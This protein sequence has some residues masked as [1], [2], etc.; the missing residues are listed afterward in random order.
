MTNMIRQSRNRRFACH[1]SVS[2]GYEFCKT[3]SVGGPARGVQTTGILIASMLVL[4]AIG[5]RSPG[6]P[7]HRLRVSGAQQAA[8][9]VTSWL[10]SARQPHFSVEQVW[11]MQYSQGGF[12]KL[13]AGEIDLACTDRALNAREL[14]DFG[15]R[16]VRGLRLGFLGYA[17][18]IHPSNRLDAIYSRHLEMILQGRISD[19]NQLVG[20]QIPELK[21]PINV[22]GLSKSTRAGM[23]LSHM[24][25][26]WFDEPRW[27]V[28]DSDAEIIERVA[29]DPLAIG[30][31]GI[32][33]AGDD[34]RYLGLRMARSGKAAYPSL[35][36]IE[37]EEYGLAKMLYVYYLDPP[38]P[39]VAAALEYLQ[40]RA[41]AEA[42]AETDVWPT[43][44]GRRVVQPPR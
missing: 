31:A 2:S 28:L 26:I 15:D 38:P 43:P 1:R 32:G 8:D 41:A 37:S 35:E 27:T 4:V 33:Y 7:A 3:V 20:D 9:L 17:L 34:V 12:E 10:Q 14:D 6:P 36:E 25:R 19:W 40:T 21:G 22:Y 18:Y 29:N 16:T 44:D 42:M 5:C 11:P 30:F 24:A 13:A 39:A 23:Q